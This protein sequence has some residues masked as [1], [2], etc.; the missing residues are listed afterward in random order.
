MN[1]QYFA[2]TNKPF[3]NIGDRYTNK[4]GTVVTVTNYKDDVVFYSYDCGAKR[5]RNIS[6]FLHKFQKE[7]N[8]TVC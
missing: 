1:I 2:W 8:A 3:V 7:K 6:E 5:N 4:N